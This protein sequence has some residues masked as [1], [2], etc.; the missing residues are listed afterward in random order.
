MLSDDL[1]IEYLN[2]KLAKVKAIKVQKYDLA[3]QWRDKERVISTQIFSQLNP[4]SQFISY[5]D[6]EKSIENYCIETYNCS[7]YDY[8]K[9]IKSINRFKKLKDLGI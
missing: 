1:I 2:Y 5:S 4:D 3:A 7:T 9:C 8:N 6:C